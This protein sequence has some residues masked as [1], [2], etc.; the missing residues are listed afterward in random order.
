MNRNQTKMDNNYVTKWK[1]F[2]TAFQ[3]NV[4][5]LTKHKIE[6]QNSKRNKEIVAFHW[7]TQI[8]IKK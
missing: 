8:Y 3:F 4:I 1:I 7:C 5:Q 2:N 6:Q